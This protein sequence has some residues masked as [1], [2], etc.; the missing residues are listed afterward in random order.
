MTKN[1]TC[2]LLTNIAVVSVSRLLAFWAQVHFPSLQIFE[3]FRFTSQKSKHAMGK[4]L[5]RKMDHRMAHGNCGDFVDLMKR[6]QSKTCWNAQSTSTLDLED[7]GII[8][9]SF[10]KETITLI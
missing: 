2:I 4:F 6:M 9:Y 8:N 1:F 5:R 3:S 7:E 10:S